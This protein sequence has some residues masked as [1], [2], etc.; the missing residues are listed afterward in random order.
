MFS[1]ASRPNTNCVGVA[2]VVVCT[3]ERTA[4][5]TALSTPCHDPSSGRSLRPKMARVRI[6]SPTTWWIRSTMEFACGF[7][8]VIIFLIIPYS[9]LRVAE[10]SAA[11]SFPLSTCVLTRWLLCPHVCSGFWLS[12]TIQSRGLS[13]SGNEVSLCRQPFRS[14]YQR[15]TDR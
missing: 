11:N 2:L 5:R 13:L 7:R 12:R 15:Y 14:S 1:R 9:F 10:T 4:C 3:I 8:V 6:I